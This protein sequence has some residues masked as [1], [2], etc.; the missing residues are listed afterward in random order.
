MFDSFSF[1]AVSGIKVTPVA[2]GSS[3]YKIR[4]DQRIAAA[5]AEKASKTT[6]TKKTTTS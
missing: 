4:M 2:V 6:T 3:R 1:A 5:A